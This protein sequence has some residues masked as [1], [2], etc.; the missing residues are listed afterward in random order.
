MMVWV[1]FANLFDPKRVA[2][3]EQIETQRRIGPEATRVAAPP[4]DSRR[5]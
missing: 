3:V 4:T 1:F 5:R 2:A